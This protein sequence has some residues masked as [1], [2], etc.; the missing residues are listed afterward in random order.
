MIHVYRHASTQT[1]VYNCVNIKSHSLQTT[2][3]HLN[4]FCLTIC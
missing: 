1:G 2:L 4:D 3:N